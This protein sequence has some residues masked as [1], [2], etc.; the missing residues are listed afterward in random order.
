[1]K[2]RLRSRLRAAGLVLRGQPVVFGLA[3]VRLTFSEDAVEATGR[4]RLESCE[5]CELGM[6]AG[7]GIQDSKGAYWVVP[8]GGKLR[9]DTDQGSYEERGP[10]DGPDL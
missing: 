9:L 5:A 3:K 8:E 10:E 7:S 6:P 2:K 1:M 4:L